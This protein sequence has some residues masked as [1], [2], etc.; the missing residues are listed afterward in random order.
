MFSRRLYA[1]LHCFD[2][3]SWRFYLP[4]DEFLDVIYWFRQVLGIIIG[5]VWGVLPMQ[6]FLGLASWVLAPAVRWG[7]SSNKQLSR[8][9]RTNSPSSI[10]V[11]L[12]R[13]RVCVLY[14]CLH[15]CVAVAKLGT[16]GWL[17]K[18]EAQ[19]SIDEVKKYLQQ[20]EWMT[21][22]PGN[23]RYCQFN[24]SCFNLLTYLFCI[25]FQL[26]LCQQCYNIHI[27]PK[28]SR[29]RRRWLRRVF[30][31]SERRLYDIFRWLPRKF[32]LFALTPFARAYVYEPGIPD[33]L[34]QFLRNRWTC[35]LCIAITYYFLC[36]PALP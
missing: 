25:L 28:F 6:G 16:W 13:S 12:K 27:L 36:L 1:C 23:I 3:A 10:C 22:D 30:R 19:Y 18:L 33:F 35:Y 5:L 4:Q 9:I 15:D 21:W 17:E 31:I 32:V 24:L 34:W 26:L 7:C 8:A 2:T 14:N 20:F 29:R 11:C